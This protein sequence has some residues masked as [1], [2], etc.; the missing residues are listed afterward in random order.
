MF[1]HNRFGIDGLPFS[2]V[3]VSDSKRSSEG[4]EDITSIAID[5]NAEACPTV[6]RLS[7]RRTETFK[8]DGTDGLVAAPRERD[9]TKYR[10]L[11]RY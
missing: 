2:W 10:N 5:K 8:S 7:R 9:R 11:H 3:L 4:W 6:S 1:P